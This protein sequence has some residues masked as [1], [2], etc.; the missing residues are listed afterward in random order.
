MTLRDD[1][2]GELPPPVGVVTLAARQIELALTP[3]EGGPTSL[4]EGLD[5]LVDRDV[6]GEP[7]RL[8]PDVRGEGEEIPT[9]IGQ[10]RRLLAIGAADVDALLEAEGPPLGIVEGRVAGGHALHA[11]AGGAVA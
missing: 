1:V 4:Q 3:L 2:A 9:L 5:A 11:A 10:R 8:A 7:A 6:D